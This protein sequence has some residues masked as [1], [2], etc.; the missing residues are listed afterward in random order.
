M[1]QL[2][3]FQGGQCLT[4]DWWLR[5]IGAEPFQGCMDAILGVLESHHGPLTDRR[6]M[7][8]LMGD[9]KA[10][11]DKLIRAGAHDRLQAVCIAGLRCSHRWRCAPVSMVPCVRFSGAV[12]GQTRTKKFPNIPNM[13]E[14]RVKFMLAL[15]L[16]RKEAAM[17]LKNEDAY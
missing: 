14:E 3:D 8:A 16:L 2:W 5:K 12:P 13:S 11:E 15:S 1:E 10:V 17:E 6:K 4:I 7:D 9:D